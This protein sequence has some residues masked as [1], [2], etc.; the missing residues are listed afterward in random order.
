MSSSFRVAWFLL[1][2]VAVAIVIVLVGGLAPILAIVTT[3]LLIVVA[4]LASANIY[5]AAKM[6]RGASVGGSE[7]KSI[8]ASIDDVLIVYDED[9]KVVFFNGAAEKLFKLPASAALGHVLSARDV[10][11][12]GWR[13]LV[14][15]IFPS[16]APRV[17]IRTKEGDTPQVA[18]VSFTDPELELRVT[19]IPVLDAAGNPLAFMKIIRDRT[20]LVAALRSKNEFITVASHQLRGPVTDI[21]WALQSLSQVTELNETNKMI[22][23]TA[24]AASQNLLHRIEDLL[25]IAKMEDGQF[26]YNFEDADIVDYVGK[27]L[28]DVLPAARKAGVKIYFDRPSEPMPH[29]NIDPKR[30]SLAVTNLLENAIRYNVENGEVTVKIDKMQD[31]PF[32]VV[33]VKDTG[34]GIP[35]EAISKLFSKFYRAENAV[36]SQ[37]EGSGLGLYI[38][39]GIIVAHGGQ[40]WAES[41]LNRGTTISFALPTDSSLVPRHE[42]SS[43][44]MV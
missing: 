10:E 19:T 39:K 4:A 30:L 6:N 38:S 41:E 17:L 13:I 3:A 28:A 11:K 20:A 31:K 2:A 44:D 42:V 5:I 26:G 37:T 25:N 29:V 8:L 9:F 18:D 35:S 40:I 14:Q 23:D 36:K 22:V 21:N 27:M 12:D 1:A 43:E 33:S 16:L 34:I 32:V 7:L 24:L 15:V